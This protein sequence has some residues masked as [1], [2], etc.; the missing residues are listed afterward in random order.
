MPVLYFCLLQA[1]INLISLIKRQ[2]PCKKSAQSTSVFHQK[3]TTKKPHGL[4]RELL[5]VALLGVS[6]F[7]STAEM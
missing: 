6:P 2:T 3:I 7:L 5:I 4:K 1:A